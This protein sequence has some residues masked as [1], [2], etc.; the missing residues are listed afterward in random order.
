MRIL[1]TSQA[2][3]L[4]QSPHHDAKEN[5]HSYCQQNRQPQRVVLPA[6]IDRSIM[7][8]IMQVIAGQL[9]AHRIEE[10][11]KRKPVQIVEQ[12]VVRCQNQHHHRQQHHETNLKLQQCVIGLVVA[13]D[14]VYALE[15]EVAGLDQDDRL[16][17][18]KQ[19]MHLM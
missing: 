8:L 9:H 6:P 14:R 17:Y 12:E 3:W 18:Y 19:V 4:V 5:E 15:H 10:E 16:P 13:F 11:A 7:Y 1:L 2:T